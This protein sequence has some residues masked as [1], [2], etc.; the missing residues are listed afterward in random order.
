MKIVLGA[1][2]FIGYH[3]ASKL[4]KAGDKVLAIDNFDSTLY[5]SKIKRLRANLLSELGVEVFDSGDSRGSWLDEVDDTDVI[6]N[7]A[8][9]AG[10]TPSW[11]NPSI[12]F[13][14]NTQLLNNIFENLVERGARPTFIQASTSSVYGRVALGKADSPTDPTSPYGISKLAAENIVKAYSNEYGFRT[15]TLRLFSVYGPHQRPDQFFSIALHAL[16][17]GAPIRIFG[18]GSNSR[19]NVFVEDAVKAF[20]QAEVHSSKSF[21]CDVSGNKEISVLELLT[22]IARKLNVSPVIEFGPARTGDQA[23]TVGDLQHTLS[24]LEW[25]PETHF[26]QGLDALISHFR[27]HPKFY[28]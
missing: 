6:F 23:K 28:L 20:T 8:A 16:S 18:D 2:G 26:E 3:L 27:A 9:T 5:P 22:L 14:N 19:A 21:T 15:R 13:E 24:T 12:Y 10:L 11:T 7:L 25:A 17:K 1:A 4:A